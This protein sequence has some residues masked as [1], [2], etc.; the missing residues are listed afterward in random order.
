M[1]E[2][3]GGKERKERKGRNTRTSEYFKTDGVYRPTLRHVHPASVLNVTHVSGNWINLIKYYSALAL[4]HTVP[5]TF[6]CVCLGFA[7][8]GFIT[9]GWCKCAS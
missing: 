1:K 6:T 9:S 5:L 2:E 7:D 8:L 4:S 3:K